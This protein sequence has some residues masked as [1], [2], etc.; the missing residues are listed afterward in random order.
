MLSQTEQSVKKC[1]QKHSLPR[2]EKPRFVRLKFSK[3]GKLQFISHLDLH[4]TFNRAIIRAGIPAWYT[5]GFNPHTKLVFATPLSIGAQ[6]T[7]E[8]LDVR[9]DREM[10]PEEIMNRLNA[11]LPGEMQITDAFFPSTPF[12][13]IVWSEYTLTVHALDELSNVVT[14][15]T[16][17][18]GQDSIV[19]PKKTKSGEKDINIQP[20]IKALSVTVEDDNLII[21]TVLSANSREYLNPEMLIK[22]ILKYLPDVFGDKSPLYNIV[23]N[24]VLL[25]DGVTEFR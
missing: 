16:D 11:E 4:R 22:A 20:M 6:S 9:V 12:S 23:R 7:C 17:L 24:K 14:S 10:S 13:D 21:N 2:L 15:L 8:Y 25:A 3:V 1:Y 19:L 5:Q 18:F